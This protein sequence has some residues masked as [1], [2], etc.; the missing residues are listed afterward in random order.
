MNVLASKE[1]TKVIEVPV[2]AGECW[3]KI[4]S[5]TDVRLLVVLGPEALGQQSVLFELPISKGWE[6]VEWYDYSSFV[7]KT[8]IPSSNV[9]ASER[10]SWLTTAYKV[11]LSESRES[12]SYEI[13]DT[14]K[15]EKK[16]SYEIPQMDLELDKIEIPPVKIDIGDSE[17]LNHMSF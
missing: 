11:N 3:G 9:S 5:C 16:E 10:N 12:I 6:F 13:L 17:L 7:I 2:E 1:G 15:E 4:S 8:T 14:A